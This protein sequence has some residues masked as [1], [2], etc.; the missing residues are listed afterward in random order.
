MYSA[1]TLA[2][3]RTTA[4]KCLWLSREMAVPEQKF[5]LLGMA[6]AWITLA[7]MAERLLPG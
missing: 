1:E 6:A 5:L 2:N 4:E 3:I 7:E